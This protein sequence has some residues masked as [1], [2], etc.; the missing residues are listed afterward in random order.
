MSAHTPMRPSWRCVGCG[1]PWPCHTRRLQLL[2]EFERAPRSLYL[3]MAGY[4]NEAAAELPSAAGELHARFLA[5]V[6]AAEHA[7]RPR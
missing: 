4:Q 7:G 2:A 1:L 5:W 3:L 6:R